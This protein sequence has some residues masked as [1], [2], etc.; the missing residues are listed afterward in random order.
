VLQFIAG[1]IA[2][3][4]IRQIFG[5][6]EKNTA[7]QAAVESAA[8][9]APAAISASIASEGS[10][11]GLGVAAYVA[12]LAVGDAAAIGIAAGGAGSGGGGYAKGGVTG[13]GPSLAMV[14][15][16]GPEFVFTHKATRNIGSRRGRTGG[17]DLPYH[18][19]AR[20]L[21]AEFD[22]RVGLST[23][24]DYCNEKAAE[25]AAGPQSTTATGSKTIVIRI[26]V[27]PGCA[28]NVSTEEGDAR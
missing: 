26:E 2:M 1:Q 17:N 9:W 19:I 28:V 27:P 23:L 8:A 18:E 16:E 10:A 25:I 4:V 22:M 12:A 3:F 6:Q 14:G 24:S 20:R 5:R 21:K 15:E 11:A 7:N 13:S